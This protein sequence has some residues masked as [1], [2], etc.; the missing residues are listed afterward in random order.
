MNPE[1]PLEC[2]FFAE[3]NVPFENLKNDEKLHLFRIIQ[4]ALNNAQKHAKA[5][6]CSVIFRFTD[7]ILTLLVCDDGTGFDAENFS[8]SKSDDE[9]GTHLGLRGM[10]ARAELLGGKLRIKS[11]ET[12]TEII[13]EMKMK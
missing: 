4:E 12:G 11:N 13:F 1:N 6:E 7:G 2:K 3:Q 8:I 9:N 10:K 5:E